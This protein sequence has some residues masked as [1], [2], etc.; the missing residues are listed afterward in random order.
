MTNKPEDKLVSRLQRTEAQLQQIQTM[1]VG[2]AAMVEAARLG[3]PAHAWGDIAA[4]VTHR[5]AVR[6]NPDVYLSPEGE[7]D[8]RHAVRS[9]LTEAPHLAPAQQTSDTPATAKPKAAAT[10]TRKT[11]SASAKAAYIAERGLEAFMALP[12][13]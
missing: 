7:G 4:R 12:L 11:L 5:D 3:A 9:V 2:L 1:A 10:A 13:E 8:L 6:L